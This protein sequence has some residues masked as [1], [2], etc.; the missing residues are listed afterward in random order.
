MGLIRRIDTS[1]AARDALS[2]NLGDLA[3][4]GAEIRERARADAERIIA[5]ATQ[6]RDRLIAGAAAEGARRG[7][8]EGY[9][10]G[11]A[12]GLEEGRRTATAEGAAKIAALE[13]SLI[14]AIDIFERERKEL[15]ASAASE[16]VDLAMLIARR[17]TLRAV[18]ID[19]GTA[20]RHVQAA[21]ALVDGSAAAR[22]HVNAEDHA[23]ISELLP[24]LQER[25]AQAGHL[26]LVVDNSLSRGSCLV[27][28]D[29]GGEIDAEI[30]RQ[31]DRIADAVG[32]RR[33]EAA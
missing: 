22:I 28:S 9:K 4:Q 12:K 19:A 11:L 13:R 5:E 2:I 14:S 29:K 17:V 32:Q 27:T 20:A 21:L 18:E 30:G 1:Q 31:L 16:I 26:S 23:A 3:R 7:Q 6:T 24:S 8:E 25:F 10:A 33:M 15:I